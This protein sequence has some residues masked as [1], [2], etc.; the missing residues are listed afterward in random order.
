[1]AK[2]QLR[3]RSCEASEESPSRQAPDKSKFTSGHRRIARTAGNTPYGEAALESAIQYMAEV[4][5]RSHGLFRHSCAMG[6]LIAGDQLEERFVTTALMDVARARG[7]NSRH[8]ERTIVRGL[9]RGKRTPRTPPRSR[10]YTRTDAIGAVAEWWETVERAEWTGRSSATDLRVLAGFGLIALRLGKIRFTASYRQLAEE[11]G[12]SVSSVNAALNRGL[13]GFVRR[14]RSG[15]RIQA[16]SSE[17]RL[18]ARTRFANSSAFRYGEESRVFG[19]RVPLDRPDHDLWHRWPNGWRIYSSL[20]MGEGLSALAI[21]EITGRPPETV[22][23]ILNRLRNQQLARKDEEGTWTALLP[24]E[25]AVD[26]GFIRARRERMHRDQ[27]ELWAKSRSV[28][29]EK[30]AAR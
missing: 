16:S 7:M 5:E 23:R 2:R 25:G 18:V 24:P 10:L 9:D 14:E 27:R 3:P 22:R 12:V 4:T 29:I 21:S 26:G 17:W 28:L 30:R 19:K 15:S 1:M 20:L 6:N 8:A 13:L 11:A